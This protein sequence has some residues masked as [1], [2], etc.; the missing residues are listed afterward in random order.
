ML[1][2]R[3]A[4][5]LR[6]TSSSSDLVREG[7]DG[8]G[9]AEGV[10]SPACVLANSQATALCLGVLISKMGLIQV[11]TSYWQASQFSAHSDFQGLP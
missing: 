3:S 10:G 8:G 7:K 1:V 4:E 6:G 2:T 9:S 5:K 11:L